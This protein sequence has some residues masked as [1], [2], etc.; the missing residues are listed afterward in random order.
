[1]HKVVENWKCIATINEESTIINASSKQQ[2]V[3]E[4]ILS[5]DHSEFLL[6][7]NS[8]NKYT[9]NASFKTSVYVEYDCRESVFCGLH[10]SLWKNQSIRNATN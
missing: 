3:E 5:S 10:T 1:M 4:V 6:T 7:H 2:I 9:N 8:A